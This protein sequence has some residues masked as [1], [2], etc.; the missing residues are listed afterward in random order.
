MTRTFAELGVAPPLVEA[1]EARGFTSAFAIQD[2]SLA[3]SLAGHDV[4]GKAQTGSGKT[5]A[6]GIPAVQRLMGQRNGVVQALMLVPTRELATQVIEELQP[7]CDAAD[8]RCAAIYGGADIDK[9]IKKLARGVDLVVATPGR[10]ID[11][12][13]RNEVSLAQV[14]HVVVDE[15][16]DGEVEPFSYFRLGDPWLA[17]PVSLDAR[18]AWICWEH[19][20]KDR[21][22]AELEAR[23]HEAG[24][25]SGPV[26]RRA[27]I[28][29]R[30]GAVLQH[31]DPK[32]Q[33]YLDAE[34]PVAGRGLRRKGPR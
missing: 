17:E 13:E 26:W 7:L 9:Q 16:D 28:R 33:H 6:F 20:G 19:R 4:C 34:H 11:L 10:M 24:Y 15:A 22:K 14:A 8:I 2:L 3:D 1:L 29:L 5:L 18:T 31:F 32:Q 30:D 27:E 23:L 12:T 25:T 21:V